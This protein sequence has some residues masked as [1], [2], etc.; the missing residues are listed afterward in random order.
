MLGGLAAGLIE[1]RCCGVLKYI[2]HRQQG[3]Q[4][5]VGLS[6]VE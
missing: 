3:G 5:F 4:R 1:A 6:T 2:S